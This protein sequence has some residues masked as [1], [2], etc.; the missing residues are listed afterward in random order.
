MVDDAD[1]DVWRSLFGTDYGAGAGAA[2]PEPASFALILLVT[3]WH[4]MNRRRAWT[5]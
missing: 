5:Q 3:G 2:V 4:A 1:F